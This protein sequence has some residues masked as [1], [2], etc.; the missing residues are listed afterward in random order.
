MRPVFVNASELELA[1][2]NLAL[3][4]R[5]ALTAGGHVWLHARDAGPDDSAGLPPAPYVLIT[6]TD[7][8][9]GI[10]AEL[11]ERVFEPFFTTNG[12]ARAP[13]WA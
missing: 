3:N 6:F 12:S 8:G 11:A 1:V 5:D 7:D 10:E 9:S 4:A 2:L 13:A